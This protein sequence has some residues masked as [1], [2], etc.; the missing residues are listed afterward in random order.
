MSWNST[1][2]RPE[3]WYRHNYTC[4]ELA[5]W[6]QRARASDARCIWAYFNNDHD[7]YA[8]Q[9]AQAFQQELEALG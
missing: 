9:N 7:A 8:I 4:P 6:A 3:R 2:T 1:A 5:E